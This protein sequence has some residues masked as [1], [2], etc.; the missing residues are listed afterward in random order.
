MANGPGTA[1]DAAAK[2]LVVTG[3]P[4]IENGSCTGSALMKGLSEENVSIS[5]VSEP[6][7]GSDVPAMNLVTVTVSGFQ[8]ISFVPVR[9]PGIEFEPISAT[10]RQAP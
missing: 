5:H 10:M 8:S 9:L 6:S 3:S 1:H 7:T 4:S 2:C